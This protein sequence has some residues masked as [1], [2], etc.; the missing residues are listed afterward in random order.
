MEKIC[1][2]F[3]T[4]RVSSVEVEVLH[5]R[6][7]KDGLDEVATIVF[8]VRYRCTDGTGSG[9]FSIQYEV[10]GVFSGHDWIP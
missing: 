3:T 5:E 4:R 1:C 8:E 6:G 7:T 10:E 9:F 2:V